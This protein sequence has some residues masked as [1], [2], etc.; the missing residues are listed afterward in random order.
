M[1][2]PGSNPKDAEFFTTYPQYCPPDGPKLAAFGS[3]RHKNKTCEQDGNIQALVAS[4]APVITLFAKTWD[5]QVTEILE[6]T[7][8]NNLRMIRDSVSY[9]ARL[10]R[11]VMLDAEHF[12]DG[13]SANPDYAIACLRTA[14]EAGASTVVL[15]DTNGGSLPWN[16]EEAVRRVVAAMPHSAGGPVRV[17]I[18]THND[19][20]MAVAN[21][22][23]AVHAGATLVQ[24]CMNG[25]GERTGNANLVSVIGTL[26]LKMGHPCL[27]ESSLASLSAISEAI[28]AIADQPWLPSMPFV[29]ANAFAHKG[30]VHVS[31]IRKNPRSYNH[32]D[33]TLVGNGMTSVLSELSGRA[34]VL[35]SAQRSGFEI[36]QVTAGS[37][38]SRIKQLENEGCAFEGA[39]ASVSLM[40]LRRM[41]KYVR[42]FHVLEYSVVSSNRDA[43]SIGSV[44]E[45]SSTANVNQAIVKIETRDGAR[46]SL[47]AAE[48]NGPVDALWKALY[49]GL[50]PRYAQ[51]DHVRI[52][53]YSVRLL[54]VGAGGNA[55]GGSMSTTRVTIKFQSSGGGT[56]ST[57]GAHTSI[58]ESSFRALIDGL[59]FAVLYCGADGT[60]RGPEVSKDSE[61]MAL[62]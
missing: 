14:A 18:H 9:F 38:L 36:D 50:R 43:E 42:K 4:G 26:H 45:T 5:M 57:V 1:R 34:N 40:I 32:I 31:A 61:L 53:D 51:L 15:C 46:P 24:G 8:D 25:Y 60:L 17:G 62:N 29:G 23:A 12:F 2:R 56:W 48:G 21:S 16:V 35:D 58:V 13:Y 20:E 28:A 44:E 41:D 30:G 55:E 59:E 6:T 54:E 33:P 7:L 22:V 37:V 3:T 49:A 10:G 47:H 39:S 27:P 19:C 52:A 11:E